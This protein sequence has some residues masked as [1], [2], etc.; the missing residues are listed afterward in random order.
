MRFFGRKELEWFFVCFTMDA[1]IGDCLHPLTRGGVEGDQ[2][3]GQLE[4][5]KEVFLYVADPGFDAAFFVGPP[6]VTGAWREA[7]MCGKVE[8]SRG[9]KRPFSA[10]MF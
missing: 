6:H 9:K 5:G 2:A 7:V 1:H 10:G 3:G 8:V 4:T